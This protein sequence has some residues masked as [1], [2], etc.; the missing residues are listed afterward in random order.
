MRRQ[1][2]ILITPRLFCN[3]CGSLENPPLLRWELN[4]PYFKLNYYKILDSFA[5]R[6]YSTYFQC[7]NRQQSTAQILSL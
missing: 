7:R 5:I 1:F 3:A 4:V 6:I 2:R